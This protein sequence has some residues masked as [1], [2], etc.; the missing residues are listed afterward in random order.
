MKPNDEIVIYIERRVPGFSR[1]DISFELWRHI[2][3]YDSLIMKYY[4]DKINTLFREWQLNPK[5]FEIFINPNIFIDDF[6]CL[7]DIEKEELKFRII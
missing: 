7:S 6:E 3:G 1:I 5:F 4:C 2:N